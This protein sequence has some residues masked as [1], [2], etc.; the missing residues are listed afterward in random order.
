MTF[1]AL[2]I[3]AAHMGLRETQLA[4]LLQSNLQGRPKQVTYIPVGWIG[5][6]S[7]GVLQNAKVRA[8]PH[9]RSRRPRV[10]FGHRLFP[11]QWAANLL[12]FQKDWSSRKVQKTILLHLTR[13][14]QQDSEQDFPLRGFLQGLPQER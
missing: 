2:K 12:A 1:F 7:L 8:T 5:Q 14:A 4:L 13:G 9:L 10:I 3:K 11:D 6:A